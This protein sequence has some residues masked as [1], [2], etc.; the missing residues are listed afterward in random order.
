MASVQPTLSNDAWPRQFFL[1]HETLT[2]IA[3]RETVEVEAVVVGAVGDGEVAV[4]GEELVAVPVLQIH[5]Q[6]VGLCGGQGVESV[7][8][9][10]TL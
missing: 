1:S 3:S 10:C 8:T 2:G 7:Q 9:W 6:F 4:G 5:T